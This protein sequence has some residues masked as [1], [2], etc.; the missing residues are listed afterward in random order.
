M[1][2]IH[3]ALWISAVVLGAVFIGFGAFTISEGFAAKDL[4]RAELA[5]EQVMT[6]RDASIPGVPVTSE[7]TARAQAEAIKGH[8]YGEYGPYS[9]M[10][11]DDPNRETYL[12]GLTLRNSL[13]LAAMG[14][15]VTDLVI[16][17]GALIVAIGVVDMVLLAPVLYWTRPRVHEATV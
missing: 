12:K 10:E 14:F 16:G 3:R 15:K 17:V 4:I 13:N 9:A 8:T 7:A 6:A 5:D 2:L 11:R 1:G